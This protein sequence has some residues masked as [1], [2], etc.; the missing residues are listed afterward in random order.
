MRKSKIDILKRSTGG[1]NASGEEVE[2]FTPTGSFYGR[3]TYAASSEDWTAD[4]H[5]VSETVKIFSEKL[6]AV[7]A[8]DRLSFRGSE[9]AVEATP[10]FWEN[11]VGY[12]NVSVILAR[13]VEG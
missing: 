9:W 13:R 6:P 12:R 3:I 4:R 10:E 8:Y 2:T 5:S 11:N 1:Y 7:S